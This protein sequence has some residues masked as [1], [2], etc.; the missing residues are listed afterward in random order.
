[1]YYQKE[2]E[3]QVMKNKLKGYVKRGRPEGYALRCCGCPSQEKG[4]CLTCDIASELDKKMAEKA[5][6]K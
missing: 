5:S 4:G 1:M 6:Q 2:R 3:V